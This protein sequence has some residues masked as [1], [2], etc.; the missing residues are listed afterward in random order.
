MLLLLLSMPLMMHVLLHLLSLM[1]VFL[2][3][4]CSSCYQIPTM[5]TLFRS[6]GCQYH[7]TYPNEQR[8]TG[9][10]AK[11]VSLGVYVSE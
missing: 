11:L 3:Y 8:K 9:R 1:L 2:C 4:Y 5:L 6:H 10:N 7:L